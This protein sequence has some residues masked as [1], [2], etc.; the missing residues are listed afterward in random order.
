V[1]PGTV[2]ARDAADEHRTDVPVFEAELDLLD[3]AGAPSWRAG[4]VRWSPT[5]QAPRRG[6]WTRRR[7]ARAADWTRPGLRGSITR[8]L[9]RVP[10]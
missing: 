6:W 8:F 7:T 2:D 10:S 9:E 4:D 3:E 1:A 5:W